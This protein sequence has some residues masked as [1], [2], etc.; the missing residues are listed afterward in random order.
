MDGG[1]AVRLGDLV[2]I[3]FAEPVVGS[4]GAGVGEDQS[5]DGI[6]DGGVLLDAPVVDLQIIVDDFL[7][8]KESRVDIADFF[9][10]SA[11][12]NVCFCYVAVSGFGK[13]F[14]YAVL[15]ILYG[16]LS[17]DDLALKVRGDVQSDQ[18]DDTGMVLLVQC[19][20]GLGD[21]VGDLADIEFRDLAISFHNLIQN[22][23]APFRANRFVPAGFIRTVSMIALRRAQINIFQKVF[24]LTQYLVCFR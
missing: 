9:A 4:D 1:A 10:L 18:F 7:I 12:K 6:G 14:F 21:R 20:E 15:N 2:V 17:V 3:H 8:I 13:D 19:L 5:A 16:D 11:V 24:N 22:E 23:S